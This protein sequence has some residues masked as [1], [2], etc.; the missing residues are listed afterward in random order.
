MVD[1]LYNFP[2][3]AVWVPFNESWGQFDAKEISQLLSEHDSQSSYRSRQWL[4]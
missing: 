3:I 4:E 1:W 2:S